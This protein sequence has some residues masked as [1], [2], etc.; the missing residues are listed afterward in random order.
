MIKERK[1]PYPAAALAAILPAKP[2]LLNILLIDLRAVQSTALH[3]AYAQR[4]PFS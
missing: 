2:I 4:G 1:L 3:G